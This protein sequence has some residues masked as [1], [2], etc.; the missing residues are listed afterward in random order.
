MSLGGSAQHRRSPSW[1]LGPA[2]HS[3]RLNAAAQL[4]PSPAAAFPLSCF[5]DEWVPGV[6]SSSFL[7]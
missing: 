4:G 1:L 6:S 5:T 7:T 2:R 3:G